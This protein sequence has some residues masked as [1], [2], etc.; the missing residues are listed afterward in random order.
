[1]VEE[2]NGIFLAGGDAPV[3]LAEPI[4][5]KYSTTF[6]WSHPFS[7]YV[8]YDRFFNSPP[9]VRT[10]TYFGSPPLVPQLRMYLMDGLFLNQKKN[11]NIRIS[12]SLKYKHSKKY[13]FFKS[14]TRPK[15]LQLISVILSHI[16]GIII[17]HFKPLDF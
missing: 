6:L 9:P 14:H 4:Y 5:K 2:N 1:M 8:S 13:I 10:C 11:S 3:Y 15:I 12:Y 16:N 17:V 7:P